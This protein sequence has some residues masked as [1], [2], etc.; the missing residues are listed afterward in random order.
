[1]YNTENRIKE[2]EEA[3]KKQVKE[4]AMRQEQVNERE[5]YRT[6][7]LDFEANAIMIWGHLEGKVAEADE[8]REE[9]TGDEEEDGEKN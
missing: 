4:A 1:M 7:M 9:G 3:A 5:K 6:Q 8:S 2:V